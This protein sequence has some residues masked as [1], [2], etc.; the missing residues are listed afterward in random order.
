M[1]FGPNGDHNRHRVGFQPVYHHL[2]H[3]EKIG[4]RTIHLIDEGDTRHTVLIGLPPDG[5]R[6]RLHAAH[7]VVDHHCPVQHPHGSLHF[8]GEIDVPGGVNNI[9]VVRLITAIH[10][11]PEAAY[12]RRGDGNAP[13]LLLRHPVGDRRAI[14]D[15]PQLVAH[16]G[17]KQ[18]ALGGGGFTGINMCRDADVAITLKRNGPDHDASLCNGH[19]N[20]AL[21]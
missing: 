15:L 13:L 10:P 14:V 5:F 19:D 8:N 9:D 7:R 21:G 6:L 20:H 16:P 11:G 1:I 4:P 17:V 3:V 2:H 12:R 18:D